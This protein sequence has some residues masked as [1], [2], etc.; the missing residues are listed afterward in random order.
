MHRYPVD[1]EQ[2]AQKAAKDAKTDQELGFCHDS[3]L[4]KLR[5]GAREETRKGVK[6]EK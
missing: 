2:M 5:N 4:P 6:G 3:A 1:E